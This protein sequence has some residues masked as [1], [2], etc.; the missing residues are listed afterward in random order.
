MSC[1]YVLWA[2]E[3]DGSIDDDIL[4]IDD[5]NMVSQTGISAFAVQEIPKNL[6]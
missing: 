5:G 2:A 6:R 4:C 1:R 3:E